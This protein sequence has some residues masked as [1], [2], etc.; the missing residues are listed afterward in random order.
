MSFALLACISG[1]IL[2]KY[3]H[4]SVIH[5]FVADESSELPPPGTNTS[6]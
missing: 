2:L 5:C 6:E 3:L 4:I 1:T